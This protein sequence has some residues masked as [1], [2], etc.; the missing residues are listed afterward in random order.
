MTKTLFRKEVVMFFEDETLGCTLYR[1]K[2]V[3]AFFIGKDDKKSI[4]DCIKQMRK[5]DATLVRDWT[6]LMCL[7]PVQTTG[8]K[9]R[10]KFTDIEGVCR[11]ILA[12]SPTRTLNIRRRIALEASR[13]FLEDMSHEI[14][15]DENDFIIGRQQ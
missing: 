4:K 1:V 11:L 15:V 12:L 13:A 5:R 3:I 10:V 14:R 9:Q 6:R 8:G 7:R 2:D